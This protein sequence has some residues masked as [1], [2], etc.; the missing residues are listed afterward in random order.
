MS[1]VK[2]SARG[3]RD[4]LNFGIDTLE[5]ELSALIAQGERERG[6]AP[7]GVDG[8]KNGASLNRANS[9]LR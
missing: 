1:D 5:R 9:R 3:F 2:R 7:K 4:A 6:F 8:K